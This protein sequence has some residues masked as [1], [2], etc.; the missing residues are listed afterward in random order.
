MASRFL[1][2]L[3][4]EITLPHEKE[5][6]NHPLPGIIMCHDTGSTE[7]QSDILHRRQ[8]IL[9]VGQYHALW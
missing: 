5:K 1:I 2:W 6:D 4:E 9:Y 8:S 7:H 3:Y